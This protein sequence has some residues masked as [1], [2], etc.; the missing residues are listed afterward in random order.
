[1]HELEQQDQDQER[2]ES[3]SLEASKGLKM[4][5]L[6]TSPMYMYNTCSYI[7]YLIR[8]A[9]ARFI[10]LLFWLVLVTPATMYPFSLANTVRWVV[11]TNII[12]KKSFSRFRTINL[13]SQNRPSHGSLSEVEFLPEGPIYCPHFSLMG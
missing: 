10:P 12:L 6:K 7:Q 1:M 3:G 11:I 4:R 2:N 8:S 13:M 5:I 9:I